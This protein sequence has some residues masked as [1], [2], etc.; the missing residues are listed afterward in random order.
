MQIDIIPS[1][2][3]GLELSA[4]FFPPKTE[5]AARSARAASE[6]LRR[7]G[8]TF[9]SVTYGA[10]GS[11]QTGTL[12]TAIDL[13]E[14]AGSEPAA[15]LTA[16]GAA[17]ETV[18]AVAQGF[19]QAGIRR[20]VALRGDPQ[21]NGGRYQAHPQGYA[22]AAALTEGLRRLHEFDI[23]VAAYPEKHP[24]SP[25]VDA[26]I[27]NLK[28]KFDAGA[29]RAITQFF[30]DP[31]IYLRFR[32]RLAARGVWRSVVPGILPIRNLEQVQKFA[33]ACE[34]TIPETVLARFERC[35]SDADRRNVAIDQAHAL[36]ERL[37]RHGVRDFHFY[38]LNKADM[39][40]AILDRLIGSADADRAMTAAAAMAARPAEA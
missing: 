26:D 32:D 4:E 21:G 2:T 34:A 6:A 18:D 9:C 11:N 20:I 19:W 22:N 25:S 30:F 40:A 17:R 39:T 33:A 36:C 35:T 29:D 14:G 12:D 5:K 28:A 31:E 37:M 3:A 7:F 1:D 10:G 24:E 8:L 23:S 38:T 27:D 13:A 16:V 15:H